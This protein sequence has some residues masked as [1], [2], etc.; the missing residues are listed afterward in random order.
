[1][2]T[3]ILGA[4]GQLGRDLSV[5]LTGE[6]IRLTRAEADLT[7]HATVRTRLNDLRPTTVINCTAY[8]LVDK[9]EADPTDAFAVNTWGV[10]NLGL[11]CRDLGA[12]LAHFSTDYVFGIDSSRTVPLGETDLPGPV[13]N[14]GLS[15]LSG[16]H[17]LRSVFPEA[18]IIRTCGLYG[19]HGVGGK[20]G[21]F[22]ETMRRLGREKGAVRVVADQRCTP[23]STIDLGRATVRALAVGATGVLHATNAGSCTW[24]EF[25]SEIFRIAGMSVSVTPIS[26]AEF[27]APARRPAYSV[28]DGAHLKSLIGESMPDWKDALARYLTTDKS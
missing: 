22:V 7:D 15:K 27:G 28:L 9:A 3:V 25:A 11:V 5:L 23:T 4:N 2:K 21:N 13:G 24:H 18:L 10:R 14:Y 17:A 19:K 26:T 8:N 6:V 1:M 16:E 12:K 20:G